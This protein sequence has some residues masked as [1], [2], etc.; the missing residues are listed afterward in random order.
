MSFAFNKRVCRLITLVCSIGWLL[1]CIPAN[2]VQASQSQPVDWS[3][4][5]KGEKVSKLNIIFG[6]S[7]P[8]A[9][10]VAFV[11]HVNLRSNPDFC[12][13]TFSTLRQFVFPPIPATHHSYSPDFVGF[14]FRLKP[15]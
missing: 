7:I 8:E 3:E 6:E 12:P 13:P 2:A 11:R 9:L 10:H 4:F 1:C 5:C 14:L 15:F